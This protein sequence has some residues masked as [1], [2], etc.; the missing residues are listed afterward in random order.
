MSF[1]TDEFVSWWV[2]VLM[3]LWVDEFLNWWVRELGG[4]SSGVIELSLVYKSVS[5][6]VLHLS[7]FIEIL[8]A[9]TT[10]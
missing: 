10:S 1:W 2:C 9:E 4:M 6:L 8:K 7:Q 5:G 3:I